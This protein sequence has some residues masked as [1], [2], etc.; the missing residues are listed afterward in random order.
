MGISDKV[1]ELGIVDY[2]TKVQHDTELNEIFK[3]VFLT[4]TT[5]EWRDLFL[6]HDIPCVIMSHF[7][8]V[9]KDEQAWVNNYVDEYRFRNGE[10]C[11]M[12]R[13]PIHIASVPLLPMVP[14][15]LPGDETDSI[16]RSY[17]YSE[18]EI[19]ALRNSG[20]VE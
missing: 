18:E 5:T 1:R 2:A 12:P 10:T 15:S 19:L 17:G 3:A 7:R 9:S 13:T 16:L 20:T 11:V 14:A 4:K 6:S 8:D